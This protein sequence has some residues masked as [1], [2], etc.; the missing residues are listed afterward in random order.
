M[1]SPEPHLSC[2]GLFHLLS[3]VEENV[4]KTSKLHLEEY[5]NANGPLPSQS[6]LEEV[7]R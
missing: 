3:V 4:E 2:A 7:V 1:S 5:Y 6:V